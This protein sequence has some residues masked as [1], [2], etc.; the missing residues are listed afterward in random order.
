MDFLSAGRLLI[1][2]YQQNSRELPWRGARDPYRVW[3]SE[4]MLQ[5]T[6]VETVIPYYEKW[7][8]VFPDLAS[9]VSGSESRV[10]QLWEGL[11]YY[12]R[13]RNLMQTAR[14]LVG[15]Y[16]GEFPESIHELKK[17]PGI[18]DYVAGALASIALGADEIALD[19]NGLRVMA[20]LIECPLPVNKPEGKAALRTVMRQMLPRGKAGDFNQ[21]VMDLGALVCTPKNPGCEHC[22]LRSEC[23]AFRNNTR[24]AYPVKERKAS[25]P[26]YIVVAAVIHRGDSVLIDKRK[27]R[28]LLGGLWEFPGGKVEVGEDLQTAL[29]R[30]IKEELGVDLTVGGEIGIYRHAY[31]HFRVT[32]HVFAGEINQGVPQALEA[33]EIAWAAVNDLAHYPMG[34]VDRLISLSLA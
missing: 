2:W 30:E 6:R 29:M 12:A 19:G 25:I 24:G 5:Q 4:V 13:A 11:G 27:A 33:D 3:I 28:G 9:L 22:P 20:R 34:K 18:G 26:H 23:E 21:A 16:G 31:T 32:V 15:E 10:M 1:E 17:L 8:A 14:I 7:M